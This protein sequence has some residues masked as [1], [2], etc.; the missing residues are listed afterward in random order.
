MHGNTFE[1]IEDCYE[2]DRATAPKDGSAN[3]HGSCR[4]RMMRSGS[5]MSNPYMQ[6]SAKRTAPYAPTLQGR[7]YMSIRVAKTLD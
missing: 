2:P 4:T 3:K 7:N 5:Y 6:R 1:W